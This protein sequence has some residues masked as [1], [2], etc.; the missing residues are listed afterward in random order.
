VLQVGNETF[1][2]KLTDCVNF[3]RKAKKKM[4]LCGKRSIPASDFAHPVKNETSLQ[5]NKEK[6]Y[7]ENERKSKK[8]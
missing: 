1:D 6:K 7:L 3:W 8:N 2:K 4:T 5:T